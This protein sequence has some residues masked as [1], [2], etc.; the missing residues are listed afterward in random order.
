MGWLIVMKAMMMRCT[1]GQIYSM[2]EANAND[3]PQGLQT[4]VQKL[5]TVS[6]GVH[7]TIR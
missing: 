1:S 6:S 2:N 4:Y 7:R 3:W 5:K